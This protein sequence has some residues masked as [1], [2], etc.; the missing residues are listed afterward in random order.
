MTVIDDSAVLQTLANL[1]RNVN[2][3]QHKRAVVRAARIAANPLKAEVRNEIPSGNSPFEHLNLFKRAIKVVTAKSWRKYPG[4]NILVKGP[5]VPVGQ[6]ES[7][8]FW[9]MA[10]YAYLVLFGNY[11]TPNRPTR[12][13]GQ[14]RGNVEGIGKGNIFSEVYNRS[15]GRALNN[16]AN[17]LVEEIKKE[18]HKSTV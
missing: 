15:G 16:F 17:N 12:R 9:K 6:G 2:S 3:S 14:S 18:I 7:R 10:G 5:D 11:Q 1:E 13:G 8:R 4:V